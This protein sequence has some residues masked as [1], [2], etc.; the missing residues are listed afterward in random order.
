MGNDGADAGGRSPKATSVLA[1]LEPVG[2]QPTRPV[3]S[4]NVGIDFGST[5]RM[6]QSAY[7]DALPCQFVVELS[8][9]AR[10]QYVVLHAMLG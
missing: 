4:S 6:K 1:R 5:G 9:L 3:I 10:F 2:W 8:R 7:R